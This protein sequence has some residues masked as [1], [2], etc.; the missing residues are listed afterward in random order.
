VLNTN[1]SESIIDNDPPYNIKINNS[2]S[3]E[4]IRDVMTKLQAVE[5]YLSS[6]SDKVNKISEAYKD[7][8]EKLG[9]ISDDK[10]N[11]DTI[12]E[13]LEACGQMMKM[14]VG[15]RGNSFPFAHSQFIGIDI[16]NRHIL[17]EKMKEYIRL[18]SEMFYWKF[19]GIES[20]RCPYIILL[21]AYAD[22]GICWEPI[23]FANRATGRGKI[24]IPIFPSSATIDEVI[25]S[26]LAD[27]RWQK[28]KEL[29][30]SYWMNEG[31]TGN[32]YMY[33]ESLK[34]QKRKG[35]L[36]VK[37]N[38]DL[39]KSFIE[40]YILWM[41][42]E[43]KGMQK[44]SKEARVIFWNHV[45][46]PEDLRENLKDRGYHFKILWENDQRKKQS[47]GY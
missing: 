4:N 8:K 28:E 25:L 42:F 43:S 46:F 39:K 20:H 2:K 31:I 29:L 5:R 1:I 10:N 44:L 32:Y 11:L 17:K 30:G 15:P 47:R 36:K 38:K 35:T 14:C 33:H 19:Q 3:Y 37:F 21:P 27:Y 6:T 18:D 40:D 23:D 16:I 24:A 12:M 41:R 45:S 34:K 22:Q 26:G 7:M 13:E 9:D